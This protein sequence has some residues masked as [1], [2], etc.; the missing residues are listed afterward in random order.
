MDFAFYYVLRTLYLDLTESYSNYLDK[1]VSHGSVAD[2]AGLAPVQLVDATI[3]LH[4]GDE[5]VIHGVIKKR[6][7]TL[8]H[9]R[10]VLMCKIIRW[11]DSCDFGQL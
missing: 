7:K 9:L 11:Q 8:K 4:E 3:L 10:I 5:V 1:G 2:R 6:L